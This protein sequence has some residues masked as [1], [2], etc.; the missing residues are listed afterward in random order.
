MYPMLLKNSLVLFLSLLFSVAAN[1]QNPCLQDT[2]FHI[3]VL[4][5]ST[6]AGSGSST[7]DSAW[8]NRYRAY[9]QSL[10][11]A[12]QVT[13]RAQGGYNTYRLLPNGSLPPAN[14][15]DPDT[16]RNITYGIALAPDA[17]IVN[18]P[19]NDVSSGYSVQEQM[20]NWDVI[21]GEAQ[22]AGIPIWICTTQ[23]KN[24]GNNPIPIQKQQDVRDSIIARYSPF[25]IDFWT[26]LADS[27]NQL[28]AYFD[29]GDGT[30]L[31][32]T[33]H[34]FLFGR[35][36][37]TDIPGQLYVPPA[38]PD[39][40]PRNIRPL[41]APA[42]GDSMALYE[43]ALLNR[44]QANS[45]SGNLDFTLEYLP[46]A[47]QT[48]SNYSIP[49]GQG[50][51][52]EVPQMA[53]LNT[54]L[55]GDYLLT[56][57]SSVPGDL[58]PANDTLRFEIF[59]LGIPQLSA[60]SDTGCGDSQ[61]LLQATAGPNDSIQ[62][63]DAPSGG[64]LL[65]TGGQF[66][67]PVLSSTTTYYVRA[68]RGEFFYRNSLQTT[69]NNNI[70]F[71]GTMFD[72]YADSA[73]VIDSLAL[74][75]TSPGPQVVR[76]FRRSGTHLGY[77][78]NPA[79]WTFEGDFPVLVTN[80]A[81]FVT[82]GNLGLALN[83]GDSLA[84]YLSLQNANANL[85]YRSLGAP[86]TRSTPELQITTGSGAAFNFGGNFY[87][88]DWNGEVFYHFGTKPEGDCQT[89]RIPVQAIVSDPQ[90][91]LGADT[92][93]NNN[94]SITLDAGPGFSSYQWSTG[95]NGQTITL[96]GSA[97][98]TGIYSIVVQAA[99]GFGCIASDTIIV[100]FAPLVGV[101]APISSIQSWPNPSNGSFQVDLP[102]GDW[103]LRILDLNGRILH[104][105]ALEG[106]GIRGINVQGIASG[107]YILHLEGESSL[108]KLIQVH[109]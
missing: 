10:N 52:T 34:G 9:L 22:N 47:S 102:E 69:T 65:G 106:G 39:F 68:L 96:D 88:R 77:E 57:I 37:D 26:G 32:D 31:N 76:L 89:P 11:P 44:G 51:C 87:P 95:A 50:T 61:L 100:V 33:G 30:H 3:V 58:N 14:R 53:S 5:S 13:N 16:L 49:I 81:D 78:T 79:A 105:E 54:S 42:C 4:G 72:L 67:S 20:D 45:Q 82:I 84:L 108:R 25:V 70:N 28:D 109:R 71:N 18:L 99:D 27:S 92:I 36:R 91:S 103:A 90:V 56:V 74:K 107:T 104:G 19:S 40:S 86:L 48:I 80:P 75:V 73:L 64:I 97:L 41:F 83:A 15:P 1:G 2:A 21:W 85:G 94:A 46:N 24:Y 43:V 35:V 59:S 101:D 93:L 7:A 8:V 62:W 63:Y 29:S 66:A 55:P 60:V 6:A 38:Y 98:G 23:P 17:I 12:Y